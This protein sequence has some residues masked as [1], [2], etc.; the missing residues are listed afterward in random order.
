MVPLCCGVNR[1]LVRLS[2]SQMRK[3]V[4]VTYPLANITQLDSSNYRNIIY[5][6]MSSFAHDSAMMSLECHSRQAI[7]EDICRLIF[8]C[9]IIEFHLSLITRSELPY[10]MNTNVDVLGTH[11]HALPLTRKIHALLSCAM[12]V[13]AV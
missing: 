10:P 2:S 4:S 9:D 8:N 1:L 11:I 5:S 7:G 12:R 13:G 6:E 3:T